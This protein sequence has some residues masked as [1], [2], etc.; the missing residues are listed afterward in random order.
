MRDILLRIPL[1]IFVKVNNINY[2]VPGL[3]EFLNHPVK[4]HLPVKN[5]P[6]SIRN[7][8]YY[9]RKYMFNIHEIVMKLC[10][11]GLA[12]FGEQLLKEKDQVFIYLNKNT[13]LLDTTSSAAG[14]HK[15]EDKP[16]PVTKYTFSSM[17]IVENYWYDV[18]NTCINTCLGGRSVVEG[19]DIL[20]EDL[21][22]KIEMIQALKVKQPEEAVKCDTGFVPGDRKGAAG[23]DSAFFPHLKRNWNW[24]SADQKSII[25]K[26]NHIDDIKSERGIT[27]SS[28]GVK[29]LS[30]VMNF[31]FKIIF[32]LY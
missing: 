29:R 18:W 11:L 25:K 15:I 16:Y 2:E 21:S 31:Y 10:Y 13:E 4:Q 28:D 26:E 23:I 24:I 8:L 7:K 20:L 32:L 27:K 22:K 5:L 12:Q 6:P 14:Y 30:M 17:G 19:K 9:K 1:S 3:Q